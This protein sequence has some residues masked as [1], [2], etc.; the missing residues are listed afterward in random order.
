[1]NAEHTDYGCL[2]SEPAE[3]ISGDIVIDPELLPEELKLAVIRIM[4]DRID[5]DTAEKK[6][7]ELIQK[8][9]FD[10]TAAELSAYLF[11]PGHA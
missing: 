3:E 1:M 7:A 9:E 8:L 10:I 5:R 11:K 6:L 2:F 4:L